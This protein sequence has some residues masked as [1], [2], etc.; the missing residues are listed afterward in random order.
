MVTW[1][2]GDDAGFLARGFWEG[3][4]QLALE[5]KELIVGA[6]GSGYGSV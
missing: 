4:E 2:F 1:Q 3:V 5:L 6:L